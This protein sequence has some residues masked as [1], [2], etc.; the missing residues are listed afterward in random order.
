M[1]MNRKLKNRKSVNF[2]FNKNN[3]YYEILCV[4]ENLKIAGALNFIARNDNK[5]WL[6]LIE[7]DKK[8]K[9]Q[10]VGSYLLSAME[11]LLVSM[12]INCVEGQ[13]FPKDNNAKYFYLSNGYDIRRSGEKHIVEKHFENINLIKSIKPEFKVERDEI[14]IKDKSD[15]M[16]REK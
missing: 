4:D 14:I 13:F 16:E 12:D 15:A 8:L 9:Q 5:A 1:C 10:G 6:S 3:E 7:V 2:E 11:E